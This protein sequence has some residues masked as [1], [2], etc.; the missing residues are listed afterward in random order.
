MRRT[1]KNRLVYVYA[2]I[3]IFIYLNQ[4]Q[5]IS[6]ALQVNAFSYLYLNIVIQLKYNF[7]AFAIKRILYSFIDIIRWFFFPQFLGHI[8]IALLYSFQLWTASRVKTIN[9]SIINWQN[10]RKNEEWNNQTKSTVTKR[11]LLLLCFLCFWL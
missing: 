6:L 3:F 7:T 10:S 8:A 5:H 2:S 9:N 11:L 4:H 1:Q